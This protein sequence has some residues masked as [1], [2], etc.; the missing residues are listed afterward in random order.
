[1]VVPVDATYPAPGKGFDPHKKNTALQSHVAFFD[2]D[3]D[4]VI[5][6]LDTFVLELY[7]PKLD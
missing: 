4:G 1:M 6:P 7:V 2:R 5:W 3:G